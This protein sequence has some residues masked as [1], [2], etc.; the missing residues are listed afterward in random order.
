MSK[1]FAVYYN[2]SDGCTYSCD[3][4]HKLYATRHAAE[5]ELTRLELIALDAQK[6]LD[7][8]EYRAYNY[9]YDALPESDRFAG[10][11][12]RYFWIDEIEVL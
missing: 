12:E 4:L 7:S 1:V 5:V 6:F 3:V 2:E 10:D 9:W 8:G 11:R